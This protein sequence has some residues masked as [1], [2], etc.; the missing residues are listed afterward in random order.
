MGVSLGEMGDSQATKAEKYKAQSM[1][2]SQQ[3]SVMEGELEGRKQK[4]R[5]S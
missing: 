2:H 4:T 5:E 3:A 1:E